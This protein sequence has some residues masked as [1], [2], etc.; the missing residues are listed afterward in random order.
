MEEELREP[1]EDREVR[2]A[3]KCFVFRRF[4]LNWEV[5]AYLALLVLS[6]AMH[7]WDLGSRAIHHDESLHALYSWHLFS[8]R[9]YQHDPMMHGPFEF[10]GTALV[11][12]LF[13]DSDYTARVLPAIFG[14]AL[15]G[16]P[17]L[18][19]GHLGRG[20]ALATAVL[21]TFSPTI[22]YYGR[23]I[24]N[25]IFIAFW[26]FGLI[27]C[28]WRY[29][30]EKRNLYLYL[31]AALLSFSFATK[32]VTYITVAIFGSFLLFWTAHD[33]V[34][35]VR[36]RFRLERLSEPAAFL[37]LLGTLTLPQ[38]SAVLGDVLRRLGMPIQVGTFPPLR[39]GLIAGLTILVFFLISAIIG[40]R[41]A[42]RTWLICAL[43]FYGVFVVL[44]TTFFTNPGG[45][46]TGIWGSLDYWL[47]QHGVKRG[48]QP[49]YYYL[50]LLP[51]YE[52]LP[53]AFGIVAWFYYALK[54]SP[55]SR[56]LVY[57]AAASLVAYSFAGEKMPWLAVHLALPTIIL[58]GRFLGEL[59]ERT[60]W[61][62]IRD[63]GGIYLALLLPVF[64]MALIALLGS[65]GENPT[66]SLGSLARVIGLTLALAL[67]TALI[68]DY[69]WRLK[70][71]RTLQ[72]LA[73]VAFVVMLIFTIRA[74]WQLSYHHGDTPVEM[75]VYT[76]TSPEIPKI[77]KDIELLSRQT[78][79]GK[80]IR[81][82]IDAES[83]FSWPW[84]WYL[85]HYKNVDYPGMKA[86]S[87][88]PQGIVVL[89]HSSNNEH[90]KQYLTGYG[91]G[92]RIPHRWW[93]PE[94]YR[95]L[96]L[97]R[98]LQG[99]GD[100]R[101][102]G[103]WWD[104]F[105]HRTLVNSLGSEDAVAYF[106][107]DFP[108]ATAEIPKAPPPAT[109]AP[110]SVALRSNLSF[111]RPGNELGQLNSP[112]DIAVDKAGNIYVVDSMNHRVQKFDANGKPLAQVGRQGAGNGEFKEPWGV[113]VDASGNV[114][115][116]DTW[117]HRIQKFDSQLSYIAQW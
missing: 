19:R 51:I 92:R 32:E 85:R 62:A 88:Q 70:L 41:W 27:I 31:G 109:E 29:I 99:L 98:F 47:I 95:G 74:A 89:V 114:Y 76:Q 18:L 11:Y 56:F 101:N 28:L 3:E 21:L 59:C 102:W 104:Y 115:V 4:C 60:D 50:L 43:I 23:F 12:F 100:G 9:G 86:I 73:I 63:R 84:A 49:F 64:I 61:K 26:T 94:D 52:F 48:G 105:M 111:G 68:M 93:F 55:F 116:A 80:D 87:G 79:T 107:R 39:D 81:I 97:E 71:R 35:R 57:W 91:P 10:H 34:A 69:A 22:L 45:F 15:V 13:G 44:Y 65:V 66:T 36:D 83:G 38:L 6:A 77:I 96:T 58:A 8:G 2:V 42:K 37:L 78:M 110:E 14:T 24:R 17:Y 106:P 53:L 72:T 25:D 33:W 46:L 67:V 82:T 75:L 117:N 1:T 20:G 16:L 30:A 54:G 112:R 40:T 90:A 108:C 103:Q 113:G 7:F 5:A